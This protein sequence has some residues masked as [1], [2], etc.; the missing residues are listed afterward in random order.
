MAPSVHCW[1]Y[2]W[3]SRAAP[4]KWWMWVYES[5]FRILDELAPAYDYGQFVRERMGPGTVNAV[6]HGHY[7]TADGK[8]VAIA[9][10]SDKIFRRFAE[11]MG[12]P[13]LAGDGA[14]G[15]TAKRQAAREVL[16]RF[17]AE[18]TG[19]Q[20]AVE[21]LHRCEEAQV[22][23]GLLLSIADIF[24]DPHYAARENLK[25]LPVAGLGA[26]MVPNVVPKLS[27]TPGSVDS[28]G[29]PLG[30]HTDEILSLLLG[31]NAVQLQEL[32]G[33]KVI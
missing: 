25:R 30:A 28:A 18:W 5:I 15:T 1:H 24:T 4:A 11:L 2:G 22:P 32:R 6:P 27:E 8:W 13:E 33:R 9:C 29:P 7:P 3:P 31:F 10:T 17:V 20:A 16:D 12:Q 14:W 23:C 19:A 26:I 21:V